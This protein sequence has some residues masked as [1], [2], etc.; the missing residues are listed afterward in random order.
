MITEKDKTE[1]IEIIKKVDVKTMS[2]EHENSRIQKWFRFGNFNAL[3]IV[4]EIIKQL[5]EAKDE[6]TIS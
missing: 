3:Q 5:P 1:L 4:C 6:G 2:I